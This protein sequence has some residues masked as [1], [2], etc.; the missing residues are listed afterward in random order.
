MAPHQ[1]LDEE[2]HLQAHAALNGVQ[3]AVVRCFRETPAASESAL[4]PEF[5]AMLFFALIA[6]VAFQTEARVHGHPAIG[7][8]L[9][10]VDERSAPIVRLSLD[11][12]RG[13]T[14]R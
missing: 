10:D 13:A 11:G 5:A 14:G 4:S 9:N 6:S 1:H 3:A 12:Y 8:I 2:R 7:G